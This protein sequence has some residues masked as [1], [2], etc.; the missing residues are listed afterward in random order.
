MNA[1]ENEKGRQTKAMKDDTNESYL[2][3]WIYVMNAQHRGNVWLI[4]EPLCIITLTLESPGKR[5]VV[6]GL[7]CFQARFKE[8]NNHSRL[9]YKNE[10]RESGNCNGAF[11]K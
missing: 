7:T 3:I 1:T 10:W 6:K 9:S 11:G 5:V 8:K 2:A 4:R